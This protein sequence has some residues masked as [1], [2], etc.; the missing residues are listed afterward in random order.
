MISVIEVQEDQRDYWDREVSRFDLVHPLNAFGWGQVRSVNGWKPTYL[1]AKR[2]D[3]VTGAIM[4]MTKHIPGTGLSIMYGQKAPLWE[5][6]DR[7]TFDGLLARLRDDARLKKAIFLRIDPNMPEEMIASHDP[8]TSCGFIHLDHRWSFWNSP[9]DVFRIDL[10]GV[11]DERELFDLLDPDARRCVRKAYKEKVSIRPAD[12]MEELKIF[13]DIFKDFSVSKGFMSRG[14]AYQQSLWKEFIS[15]GNGRLFLA[16]Y[17][18]RIIGGLILLM[19]GRKCLDM[20]MGTPYAYHKLQTSYAYVWE[21]IKWAK[22]N[23]CRWYSFRGTGSSASQESFKKKFGPRAVR[24]AGYYDLPF[25]PIAYRLSCSAE[26]DLLPRIWRQLMKMREGW[27]DVSK[28]LHGKQAP[29]AALK[30]APG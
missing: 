15:R 28:V 21:S 23:D 1:M 27:R 6:G 10:E 20:H 8:F 7:E 19:F 3:R 17:E 26:F 4:Y 13:H 14:L 11:R 29:K 9:R 2:G 5:A 24:L 12:S 22:E 16:I 25:H 30:A 18:G